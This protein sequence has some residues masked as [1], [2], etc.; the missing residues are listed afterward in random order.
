MNFLII[1]GGNLQNHETLR[2][3]TFGAIRY[4]NCTNSS[5]YIVFQLI[6]FCYYYA[7]FTDE[8]LILKRFDCLHLHQY[9]GYIITINRNKQSIN[10]IPTTTTVLVLP[11]IVLSYKFIII[12]KVNSIIVD[13]LLIVFINTV[14]P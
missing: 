1:T 3:R 7:L 10:N 4:N 14:L 6:I 5:W 12:T 2:P 8:C 9:L 13:S 11:C